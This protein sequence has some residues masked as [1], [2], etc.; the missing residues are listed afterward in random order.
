MLW[1]GKSGVVRCVSVQSST[2]F[3]DLPSTVAYFAVAQARLYMLCCAI[4][5]SLNPLASTLV[6]A[7]CCCA[8]IASDMFV[9]QHAAFVR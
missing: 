7:R 4:T 1:S 5:T 2:T 3:L 8:A 6:R 9:N